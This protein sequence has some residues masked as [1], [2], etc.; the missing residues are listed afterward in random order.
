VAD[1]RVAL[2]DLDVISRYSLAVRAE[3]A[4]RAELIETLRRDLDWLQSRRASA[5][6]EKSAATRTAAKK[7]T[8]RRR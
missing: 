4:D 6:A 1:D 7:T 5:P 8:A 3:S 2:T